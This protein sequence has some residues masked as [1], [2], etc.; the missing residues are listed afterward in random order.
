[1]RSDKRSLLLLITTLFIAMPVFGQRFTKKEQ[2][3]REARAKNF[4]YGHSFTLSTGYVHSWLTT[5]HFDSNTSIYG[6]TG[7]YCNTRESFDAF[8]SWDVCMSRHWGI[9]FSGGYVQMGGQKL[10]YQDQGLGYGPQLRDDLTETI[11]INAA[12][13]QTMARWFFP[14]TYK[15]RLS[16]NGG[17]Y[18]DRVL[19]KYDDCHDW[20]FGALVSL[21]YDWNHWSASVIY[22]PGFSPDIIKS[23]DTRAAS[24]AVNVGF[25]LW[26]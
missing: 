8:L 3:L 19:G 1:M 6:R 17:V 11:H 15:S 18:V 24:I 12:E 25:R 5:E 21:G 20:D 26:K 7:Q 10:F 16:L 4:F 2:A 14:L 23:S 22:K 9:Q 13:V